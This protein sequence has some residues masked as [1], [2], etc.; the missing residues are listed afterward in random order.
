MAENLDKITKIKNAATNGPADLK[1]STEVK[2]A[3]IAAITDFRTVLQDQLTKLNALPA[4]G[5]TGG[6]QS[7]Y[8]AKKNLENGLD[9]FKQ[10]ISDYN[11]YLDEL[12]ET[13]NEAA[14]RLIANG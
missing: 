8:Q 7:A 11:A 12:V 5:P 1:I 10:Y 9:E 13:V 6:F 14:K 4:Y 2:D 3:Y